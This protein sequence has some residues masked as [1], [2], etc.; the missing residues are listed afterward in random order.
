MFQKSY[1]KYTQCSYLKKNYIISL[2]PHN[3]SMLTSCAYVGQL[4]SNL[5]GGKCHFTCQILIKTHDNINKTG[6]DGKK[7]HNVQKFR[8]WLFFIILYYGKF[9][10]AYDLYSFLYI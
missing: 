4:K 5:E 7:K 2:H 1:C 3:S 8:F 10:Q 9:M 6:T